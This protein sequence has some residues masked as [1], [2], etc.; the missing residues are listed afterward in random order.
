MVYSGALYVTDNDT[1]EQAQL[2]KLDHHIRESGV[3]PGS[4]VL[5][6]GCGWGACLR[7][8]VE[9]AGAANA[10]GLTLSQAQAD[11]ANGLRVPGVRAFV[12]NWQ[13]HEP[14]R[15]YDAII[16]IGAFEHFGKLEDTEAQKVAAYRNFFKRCQEEFLQPGGRLSL[17]TFA[18][19]SARER[20]QARSESAT[21]FLAQEI[22]RET[23]PPSLANIAEAARF[24]FEICSL[25]N[26]RLHYAKTLRTWLARLKLHRKQAVTLVGED[27]VKRYERYLQ[28]SFIGF[29][30]GNLDLYRIT[31][32]RIEPRLRRAATQTE[33]G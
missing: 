12:E 29:Q 33:P 1:L 7:R 10:V 19:G 26:D 30:T 31:L 8:L 28:Y 18:Y 22:F 6:I 9:H 25:R 24:H 3:K 32:Q 4:Q 11:Y 16:S 15:P 2:H 17:Q 5:E 13:D 27:A 14:T 20:D 23:D 21:T